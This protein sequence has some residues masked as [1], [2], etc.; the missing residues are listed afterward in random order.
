MDRH[1]LVAHLARVLP[2]W[3]DREAAA[4]AA[5]LTDVQLAGDAVTVWTHL[6]DEADA[7]GKLDALLHAAWERRPRDR[8][9]SAAAGEEGAP[10]LRGSSTGLWFALVALIGVAAVARWWDPARDVAQIEIAEPGSAA[11]APAV[12]SPAS[13][14]G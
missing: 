8:V 13:A 14:V 12:A 7:Q 4:R 11:H 6:L 2:A 3:S 1:T 5:G 10:L 9:L